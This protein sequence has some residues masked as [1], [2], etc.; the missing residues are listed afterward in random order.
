VKLYEAV[1]S[2]KALEDKI[3]A[4]SSPVKLQQAEKERFALLEAVAGLLRRGECPPEAALTL[5]FNLGEYS[6]E[7]ELRRLSFKK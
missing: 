5:A 2:A 3:K 7:I 1:L 6:R 4:S